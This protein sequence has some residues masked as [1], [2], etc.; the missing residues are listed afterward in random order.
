MFRL[1]PYSNFNKSFCSCQPWLK[2]K[3]LAGLIHLKYRLGAALYTVYSTHLRL[4]LFGIIT[5]KVQ[6]RM[7]IETLHPIFPSASRMSS[8]ASSPASWPR[9]FVLPRWS[10]LYLFSFRSFTASLSLHCLS[11]AADPATGGHRV[12]CTI[13]RTGFAIHPK[14]VWP[15]SN[16]RM[17]GG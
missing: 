12:H 16:D 10:L 9:A 5:F 2:F 4:Q 11:D 15:F 13:V 1:P 3:P 8:T 6:L 7:G 17:S 14:G